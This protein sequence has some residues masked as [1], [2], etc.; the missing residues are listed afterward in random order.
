[1]TRCGRTAREA[2]RPRPEARYGDLRSKVQPLADERP[3]TD[4]PPSPCH[5]PVDAGGQE[6]GGVF[7]ARVPGG[8]LQR[9]WRRSTSADRLSRD[10]TQRDPTQRDQVP[11]DQVPPD[12]PPVHGGVDS[13]PPLPLPIRDRGPGFPVDERE[14]E[15]CGRAVEKIRRYGAHVA[16]ADGLPPARGRVKKVVRPASLSAPITLTVFPVGCCT[17]CFRAASRRGMVVGNRAAPELASGEP[18]VWRR[19]PPLRAAGKPA[20]FAPSRDQR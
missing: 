11:P 19:W 1:M 15:R 16:R 20:L 2:S 7:H 5:G 3:G 9:R 18:T 8:L 17:D 12:L 6:T 13:V 14:D 10:P 4:P